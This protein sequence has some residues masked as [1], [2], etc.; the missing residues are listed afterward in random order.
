MINKTPIPKKTKHI[1]M[2]PWG[3]NNLKSK[4]NKTKQ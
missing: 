1:I 2:K 3:Q 4:D